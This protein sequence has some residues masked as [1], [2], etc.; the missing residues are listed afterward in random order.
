MLGPQPGRAF[1]V[2]TQ[3]SHEGGLSECGSAPG[4]Y[5][6]VVEALGQ[7]G[8]VVMSVAFV[9]AGGA[10]LGSMQVGMLQALAA[11]GIRPDLVVGTSVGAVNAAWV[12]G[13]DTEADLAEL[14]DVWRGLSRDDVFP[15]NPVKGLLGLVGWGNHL[16]PD[17]A[18]RRLL[19]RHLR[20]KR[21]ED[22]A[23]PLHV[24]ATDVVTGIDV[25]LSRGNAID[26]IMASAAI[27]GIFPPVRINGQLLMDGAVVENTPIGHAVR[28]G[29]TTVWVL[30]SGAA[31][32]VEEVPESALGMALHAITLA[33]S[34]RTAFDLERYES[35][36]DL[37]VVPPLCPLAI[38]PS[39]FSHGAE[40]IERSRIQTE[41]WL[42]QGMP[43]DTWGQSRLLSA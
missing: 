40:L 3:P 2:P 5:R 23:I 33:I 4:D 25:E 17:R 8:A 16:I 42:E 38:N 29:A 27:P 43:T 34:Q 36:V 7:S 22:A 6:P 13:G 21:L 26:A 11:N 31:C 35:C 15:V 28:Q 1:A 20:F 9:L 19:R 37:K 39:D 30:P 14:A 32:S 18:L 10:S 41:D 12:A 24:V